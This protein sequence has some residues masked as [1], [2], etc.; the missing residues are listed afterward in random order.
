MSTSLAA[1]TEND[2]D[3]AHIHMSSGSG[4]TRESCPTLDV[5]FQTTSKGVHVRENVCIQFLKFLEISIIAIVDGKPAEF[6]EN[7]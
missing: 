3:E 4:D 7:L 1:C 6:L 2:R 5:I